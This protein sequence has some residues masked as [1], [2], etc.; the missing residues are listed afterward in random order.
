M[1]RIRPSMEE[2]APFLFM[3]VLCWLCGAVVLGMAA[4]LLFGWIGA[5]VAATAFAVLVLTVFWSLGNAAEGVESEG[6]KR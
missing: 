4:L 3:G 1:M 2:K 6:E 5:A